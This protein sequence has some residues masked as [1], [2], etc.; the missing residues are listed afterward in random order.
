MGLGVWEMYGRHESNKSLGNR[1]E[2]MLAFNALFFLFTLF[3]QRRTG[4]RVCPTGGGG[5]Q[6][7]AAHQIE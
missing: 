6:I 7:P 1:R 5:R 3:Y 2:K 4:T